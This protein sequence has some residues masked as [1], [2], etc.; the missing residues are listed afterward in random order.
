MNEHYQKDQGLVKVIN[1]LLTLVVALVMLVIGLI[2]LVMYYMP[3][4]LPEKKIATIEPDAFG[5]FTDAGKQLALEKSADTIDYWIAPNENLLTGE[6]NKDVI[7][8]GK[9]LI[10]HTS[11]YF[12]P[13]GKI[14]KS[15]TNGMNCQNC[16]LD[17]GTKIYGNNYGAVASTYPKYRARSGAMENIYKRVND[18]FERSLN[19]KTLDTNSKEMQSIVAYINWLGKDVQKGKKPE[20][21]GFKEITYLDRAANPDNG[22]LIYIQKCQ[23]CHQANGEGIMNTDKTAYSYPPL[24]G[25]QSYNNGAGL[26]RISNFAKFVKSNMPLGATHT[27]TQLTDEEAWDVAAFV[28][29]QPRPKKDLKNDWPRIEEKPF[30]HPFGPYADGFDEKQ[31]KYGPF[32]PILEKAAEFKKKKTRA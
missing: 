21:S 8:Y 3:E 31:H 19:G 14:F 11:D 29:S 6:V 28:N 12:G 15:Y 1:Q 13:G 25:N 9:D 26:Y 4:P 7:L 16:H 2:A 24:W 22:K 30:D 23:S 10:I 32:K 5:N 18:C 17:G 20:G 27:N